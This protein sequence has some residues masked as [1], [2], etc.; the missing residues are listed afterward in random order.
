MKTRAVALWTLAAAVAA[1]GLSGTAAGQERPAGAA[2]KADL[3]VAKQ[4]ALVAA[5][6]DAMVVVEYTLQYDKG[7]APRGSGFT[8]RCPQC[9]QFHS[10]DIEDVVREERPLQRPG[11]LVDDRRVVT[12]DLQIHPR[13]IKDIRVRKFGDA[14]AA[15]DGPRIAATVGGYARQQNAVFLDLAGP[16]AG[17]R[18]VTFDPRK[19]G[20]YSVLS[21]GEAEGRWVVG[22]ESFGGGLVMS[23]GKSLV[24]AARGLIVDKDGLAVG[25]STGVEMP[26]DGAWKAHPKDW[27]TVSADQMT[28]LL[29][30]VEARATK[31]VVPVTLNFRSPRGGGAQERMSFRR[32]GDGDEA[33]VQHVLG[34][35]TDDHTVLIL[36]ELKPAATARLERIRIMTDPPADATFKATLQDYGALVAQTDKPLPGAG[37]GADGG[38]GLSKADLFDLQGAALPTADIVLQGE[39]RVAFF[40][41][42]RIAGFSVGWRGNIYPDLPADDEGLFLFDPDG[43]LLALPLA[44][45]EKAAVAE[46]YRSN[47]PKLTPVAQLTKA[48]GSLKDHSDPNN[49]PLSEMQE[50][51][52]A[53]VGVELQPMSRELAR[54]N[55][56]S[57]LTKDGETGALVTY[58]YPNSPAGKA[59]VEP[60]WVF[61]R[62]DVEGQPKPIDVEAESDPYGG[63]A[64]PW[65]R[66]AE[67]PESVYERIPTPW[68]AAESTLL[69]TLTDL[70]F[71]KKFVA[72]FAHG[73]KVEKKDFTVVEGPPTYE[74]APRFKLGPLGLTVR[75]LT[76]DVRRYFQKPDDE[77]GVVISKIELGSK[78]SVAGLKPYEVITHVNDQPVKTVQD[79]EKLTKDQQ[80]LRLSVKRMTKGRIVKVGVADG[81]PAGETAAGAET[82]KGA[83]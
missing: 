43:R 71:G 53:W 72:E 78:A 49:V 34:V 15:A 21:P 51:R 19:A 35:V 31:G 63:Q 65:D 22:V 10:E 81:G 66:L 57:D 56:V 44:Q 74:S 45:R 39:K 77:P 18:P 61:L 14:P 1:G 76:Y 60:G 68:P 7:E 64:F 83:D 36:S 9:G 79:F 38:I 27:P 26:A 16:V 42:R 52:L 24:T 4:E 69:R 8:E 70:G 11:F 37:S 48:L 67:V 75:D 46:N 50:N 33:T 29:S 40:Q 2:D 25:V 12:A 47:H 54:A 32:G 62:V 41:P 6:R 13:F 5:N 58:V 3:P 28:A 30:A 23:R 55:N 73:G 80:E 20:P 59:G 17:A 82:R